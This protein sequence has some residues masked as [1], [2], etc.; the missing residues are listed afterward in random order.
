LFTPFTG[1]EET[2]Q[3]GNLNFNA[4]MQTKKLWWIGTFVGFTSKQNDFYEP[5]QSGLYFTRNNSL[6]VGGWVNSNE[7]KKYS[8]WS[9]IFV[10]RH[11]NFYDQ[12]GVDATVNQTFR[13]NSKFSVSHRIGYLPRFNNMGF[14]DTSGIN[15]IIARRKVNTIENIVNVKYSFT[16]MMWVTY[17]MRHYVSTVDNRE[18]FNLQQNGKLLPNSTF[19][20]NVDQNLNLFNI[21]MVYTWQFAPGSFLNVVWKNSIQHFNRIVEPDYFKNVGNTVDADANNNLSL[22]VIYFLDY[23]D[24]KKWGKKK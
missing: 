5:R 21:D 4:E 17:R 22:K 10:R 11:F 23:L 3:T 19:T 9:E 2:Y 1:I 6:A 20:D 7:A 13:F 16:N 15:V 12:L 24:M 18:Y 14:A 8:F